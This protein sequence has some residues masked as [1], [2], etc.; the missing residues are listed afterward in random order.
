MGKQ[1]SSGQTKVA[2]LAENTARGAGILGEHGLSWWI[3]S[4]DGAILFD[5]G[6]GL[7]VK[8]NAAKLQIDL[9][10]AAAVVFSHGHY[11]HVGGWHRSAEELGAAK[12]FM[13]PAALRPKYQ[14]RPDGR[15]VSADDPTFTKAM[16]ALTT[17]T[18]LESQTVEVIP[19]IRT[20]GEVPR[21][22][23]FEDTGGAFYSDE[24]GAVE[25][26][27]P[28]DQSI[29]FETDR[30]LVVVL[31]CAH[32]G[33]INILDHVQ[34]LTGGQRIHAVLGGMHLL[35]ANKRR[36][37]RTISELRRIAPDWIGPNHCTGDAALVRLGSA[38]PDKFFECH[39]GQCFEFPLNP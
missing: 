31:G 30:G 33:V 1:S 5:L 8:H 23:D 22:N 39:A 21:A 20:T 24:G 35:N 25:D 16:S 3:E 9:G 14:K 4:G 26:G 28:D 37:E 17:R 36:M 18:C 32:A 15:M 6:Q 7:A 19:G 34:A 11:D 10:S 2:L 38:F 27:L 12:I 29:F 13:H